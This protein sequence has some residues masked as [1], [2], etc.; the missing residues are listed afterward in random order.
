VRVLVLGGTGEGRELAD[1]LSARPGV[2][3]VSSLAGRTDDPVLPAGEVRVGGFG[4]V[5]GLVR[6]LR[7]RGI[8]RVADATHPFA[9]TISDHA[10]TAC[11]RAGVPLVAVRRE[12][13]QE[14][15]R[16]R[17]RRVPSVAAASAVTAAAA[18][19]V[20]VL[21]TVGRRDVAAF[22]DDAR[23]LHVV[24][25]VSPPQVALPPRHLLVTARGPFTV[26]GERE[27]LGRHRIGMLVTR[28]SGGAMTAPKLRAAGDLDVP[29]VLVERPP[30]PTGVDVVTTVAQAAARLLGGVSKIPER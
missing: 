1:L 3:V 9:V 7:E 26:D 11:S 17:W 18:P 27:V 12:G 6:F 16:D 4:D 13:W 29:V 28:D 14:G 10:A 2:E 23:H 15:P 20:A 21:L 25:S 22:A 8:D 5:E 30:A 19:D 24:R